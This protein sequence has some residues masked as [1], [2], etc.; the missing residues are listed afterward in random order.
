MVSQDSSV[1]DELYRFRD[2]VLAGKE[3]GEE[4][5][6]LYYQHSDEV[7]HILIDNPVLLVRSAAILTDVI[8]GIR[9]LLGDRN[10]RDITI[11]PHLAARIKRLFN[12]IGEE[13]SEELSETLSMLVDLLERHKGMRISEIWLVI[14]SAPWETAIQ[15]LGRG[16]I[17]QGRARIFQERRRCNRYMHSGWH[18]RELKVAN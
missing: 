10:G 16:L 1:H 14:M 9:H 3:A 11:T 15:A 8:P 6:E 4:L 18:I 7:A 5:I 17:L 13:G 2:E 12:D